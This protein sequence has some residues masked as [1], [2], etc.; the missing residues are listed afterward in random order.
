MKMKRNKEDTREIDHM[1]IIVVESIKEEVDIKIVTRD[2]KRDN[3]GKIVK[4]ITTN[5]KLMLRKR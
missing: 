3:Q 5:G 4:R 1:I 2:M